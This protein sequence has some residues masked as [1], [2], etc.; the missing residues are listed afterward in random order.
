MDVMVASL[1][2]VHSN[3]LIRH[4]AEC[5]LVQTTG[6]SAFVPLGK[7]ILKLRP[8]AKVWPRHHLVRKIQQGIEI[9]TIASNLEPDRHFRYLGDMVQHVL[10]VRFDHILEHGGFTK[11][12]AGGLDFDNDAVDPSSMSI[13]LDAR[14]LVPGCLST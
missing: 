5:L 14:R 3:I 6:Q 2:H 9:D 4:V 7:R 13:D 12:V 10:E 11:F 8:T 1:F